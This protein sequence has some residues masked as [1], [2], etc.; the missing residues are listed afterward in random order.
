MKHGSNEVIMQNSTFIVFA[1]LQQ[2]LR[3]MIA[4][5]DSCDCVRSV[6][7]MKCETR[8]T[9][10]FLSTL[11]RRDSHL[12]PSPCTGVSCMTTDAPRKKYLNLL[13]G[14]PC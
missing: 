11:G 7:P 4:I 8:H 6:V 9:W 1:C 12:H 3:L 13:Q 2:G 14:C 10:V 5:V